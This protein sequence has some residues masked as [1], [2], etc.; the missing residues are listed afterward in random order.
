MT[1]PTIPLYGGIIPDRNAQEAPVFTVN[2]IDWLDYQVIQIPATNTTVGAIND[3][4]IQVDIDATNAETSAGIATSA[5]NFKGEWS[6]NPDGTPRTGAATVPSSYADGGVE[7][8]LLQNIP[9]IELDQP[10]SIA[11]NWQEIKDPDIAKLKKR[12]PITGVSTVPAGFDYFA[13]ANAT[14][15]MDDV[16]DFTGG[17]RFTIVASLA[18]TLSTLTVDGTQSEEI[19]PRTGTATDTVFDLTT[20]GV[21]FEFIFNAVTG[22]WEV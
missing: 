10:S 6:T 3:T 17:E 7:W 12:T 4:A 2:S 19:A 16:T 11:P 14:I 21:E 18:A 20:I 13:T 1:I 15:T 8:Q 22:N 9:A 5:A